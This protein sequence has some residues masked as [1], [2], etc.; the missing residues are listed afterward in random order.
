VEDGRQLVP[1][2]LIPRLN[3]RFVGGRR[4][5]GP[6]SVPH[7]LTSHPWVWRRQRHLH[8]GHASTR[9]NDTIPVIAVH[10]LGIVVHLLVVSVMV[11]RLLSIKQTIFGD[12]CV[13]V[14]RP[15]DVVGVFLGAEGWRIKN[16][17]SSSS[18]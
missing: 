2:V 15:G 12:S 6:N 8:I 10:H 16:C 17:Q 11:M 3:S 9:K 1:S 14:D 13:A 18:G 5:Q 7:S 4:M